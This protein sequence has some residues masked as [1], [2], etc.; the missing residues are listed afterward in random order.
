MAHGTYGHMDIWYTWVRGVGGTGGGEEEETRSTKCNL[1]PSSPL[2]PSLPLFSS[3]QLANSRDEVDGGGVLT[4]SLGEEEVKIA[5]EL[6]SFGLKKSTIDQKTNE[7]TSEGKRGLW[8]VGKRGEHP[9][10]IV[11]IVF[12]IDLS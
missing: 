10:V 3:P 1:C 2:L 6:A 5:E 9:H 11:L 12:C 4:P 7:R 8:V